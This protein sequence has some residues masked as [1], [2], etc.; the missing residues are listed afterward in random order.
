MA[1]TSHF[2]IGTCGTCGGPV[3][4]A[5]DKNGLQA[6]QGKG[7]RPYCLECKADADVE[8]LDKWGARLAMSKHASPRGLKLVRSN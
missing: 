5:V 7:G 2:I 3:T 6:K 1:D 4:A 8:K